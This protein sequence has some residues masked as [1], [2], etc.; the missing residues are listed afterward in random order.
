MKKKYT[1]FLMLLIISSMVVTVGAAGVLYQYG[2]ANAEGTVN[3]KDVTQLRR[4]LAEGDVEMSQIE[5]NP[6]A[7]GDGAVNLKD[8]TFLRR[9]LAGGWGV[10]LPQITEPTP[11]PEPE[12]DIHEPLASDLAQY[13]VLSTSES[14]SGVVCTAFRF[15]QSVMGR[16]LVC[17][18]IH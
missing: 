7:N 1:I 12:P 17:W 16:D 18:S 5:G 13:E 9:Y 2:D 10:N 8:V 15:G 6:D 3:L 4:L 11:D 14:A